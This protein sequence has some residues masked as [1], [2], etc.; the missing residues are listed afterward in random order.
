LAAAVPPPPGLVR[1]HRRRPLR[2][3]LQQPQ[4]TAARRRGVVRGGAVQARFH[5]GHRRQQQRG[6]PGLGTA[7]S[8]SLPLLP[9]RIGWL[10]DL[11]N[12]TLA[13]VGSGF[14]LLGLQLQRR[15]IV[16]CAARRRDLLDPASNWFYRS[17]AVMLASSTSCE[18]GGGG[19][20]VLLDDLRV[21]W[22]T[23]CPGSCVI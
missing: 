13:G 5:V 2:G 4:E 12:V 11:C 3:R 7:A 14:S 16:A 15:E 23:T 10:C 18:G 17:D 1:R 19:G 9:R 21:C 20:G 22:K 8:S 6:L